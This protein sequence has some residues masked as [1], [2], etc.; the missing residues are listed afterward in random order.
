MYIGSISGPAGGA[1]GD[2]GDGGPGR[3]PGP[4]P[5]G[6]QYAMMSGEA[7]GVMLQ[8]ALLRSATW[9]KAQAW[10]VGPFPSSPETA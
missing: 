2:G 3:G 4:G 8:P 5:L 1:G 7:G 6:R 10:Q 9:A